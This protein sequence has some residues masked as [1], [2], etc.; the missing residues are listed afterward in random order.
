VQRAVTD[1]ATRQY[2]LVTR[3][4]L[5]ALGTTDRQVEHAIRTERLLRVEHGV[6]RIA[7]T[8]EG[9]R[10]RA[11]AAVLG[12]GANAVASHET[13]GVL[14]GFRYLA[15]E[16]IEITTPR[17]ALRQRHGA[18][19]HR[20]VVLAPDV[21]SVDGIPATTYERTL[22]DLSARLSEHQLG[23]IL[24]DGLRLRRASTAGLQ[25]C[26]DRLSPARGRRVSRVRRVLD[27]R[28]VAPHPGDSG[29]ERDLFA[30]LTGT[31]L[32]RPVPQ[33]AVTIAGRTYH[34]DLA[35]PERRVAI[36]YDGWGPHGTTRTSFLRDRARV[37]DLTTAGWR[38]LVFTD[39]VPE[40]EVVRQVAVVLGADPLE[41]AR[42]LR[43]RG[44]VPRR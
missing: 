37:S 17:P 8:P 3:R 20:S 44:A 1:L 25:T 10:G 22:V 34:L 15:P 33:H 21:T 5:V 2:G 42:N 9:W 7:G 13:A 36:E 24:D 19:Y 35:Y 39:A 4:Q 11:L 30:L 43:D 12:A 14:W 16:V 27:A 31:G 32:P 6:Y 38:T 29:A 23:R 41:C 18:R 40:A 28:E 26:L